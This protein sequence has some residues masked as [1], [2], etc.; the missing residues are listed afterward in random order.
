MSLSREWHPPREHESWPFK[1]RSKIVLIKRMRYFEQGEPE[2]TIIYTELIAASSKILVPAAIMS[3]IFLAIGIY[4]AMAIGGTLP[5]LE[6][7][8]EATASV[9]RLVGITS[10][11]TQIEALGADRHVSATWQFMLTTTTLSFAASLA[12]LGALSFRSAQPMSQMLTTGLLFGVC[13]GVVARGYLRPR[14]CVA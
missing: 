9:G 3:T 11:R 14:I 8:G 4:C 6:I 1:V 12:L 2:P 13:S 10:Y 5:C 7:G